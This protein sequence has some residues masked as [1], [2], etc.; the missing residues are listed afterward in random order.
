MNKQERLDK[1]YLGMGFLSCW[2]KSNRRSRFPNDYKDPFSIS[3]GFII[4][5]KKYGRAKE[6][7][8]KQEGLR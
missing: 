8:R 4:N 1:R 5:E 6:K 2:N 7:G 3:E